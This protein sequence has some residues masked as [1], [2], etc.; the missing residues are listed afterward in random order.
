MAEEY[1]ELITEWELKLLQT[2]CTKRLDEINK[3][4]NRHNA[5]MVAV[6]HIP[7]KS[8]KD[9]TMNVEATCAAIRSEHTDVRMLVLN[10]LAEC[11]KHKDDLPPLQIILHAI[12]KVLED[13][14]DCEINAA[15]IPLSGGDDIG[16]TMGSA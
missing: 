7:V 6:I 8:S 9:N 10:F 12:I 4:L 2:Y 15:V 14:Y 1:N 13:A 16:E 3:T 11:H 5:D